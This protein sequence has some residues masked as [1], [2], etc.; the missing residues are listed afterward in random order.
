MGQAIGFTDFDF[1]DEFPYKC[2][3]VKERQHV[4]SSSLPAIARW[5]IALLVFALLFTLAA[6]GPQS[7]DGKD[8]IAVP[9]RPEEVATSAA[10]QIPVSSAA[11]TQQARPTV[12]PEATPAASATLAT[13][14]VCEYTYFFEPAP[15][16]CPQGEP[17]VSA[18][19]E[20]PFEGGVMIW[21]ETTDSVIVLTPDQQWRRFEDTWT[22][23]QPESDPSIVPPDGRYQPIRGFGKV[24]REHPE[25]RE[26]LGWALG[27]ELGFESMYQ[28]QLTPEGSESITFLLTFNGQ[29]FA[30]TTRDADQGDWVIAAS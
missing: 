1:R 11:A 20:Q 21:L 8:Q 19:A 6:C 22:E 7:G 3:V 17:V 28:D 23:E 10:T 24:W 5:M 16:L 12:T 13:E 25:V 30:L 18:A 15:G 14:E 29:V 9:T 27:V 4:A 2:L 26:Q